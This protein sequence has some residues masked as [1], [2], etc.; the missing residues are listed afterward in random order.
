MV[1]AHFTHTL[2]QGDSEM[3]KRNADDTKYNW[4]EE[5]LTVFLGVVV[6]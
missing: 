3:G 4:R 1:D 2:S 6:E 5:K